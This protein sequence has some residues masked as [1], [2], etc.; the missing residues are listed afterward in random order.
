MRIGILGGG[1]LARMLALSG[2]PLGLDFVFFESRDEHCVAHLGEVV[3]GTFDDRDAMDAFANQ[4]DVITLENENIPAQAVHYLQQ[5]KPIRPGIN[6]LSY[7]QDRFFEKSLMREL[8]IPIPDCHAVDDKHALQ[9]AALALGFPF[10]LKT[11]RGGYDGKGQWRFTSQAELEDFNLPE[12]DHGYLAETMVTFDREVSLIGVRA[13]NGECRYYPLCENKHID[14]ILATT[15]VQGN[16][17]L[18]AQAEKILTQL[19][20]QLNYVGVLV[21]EFFV[22]GQQLWVNE[23]APRVHNS[24]HWS[25]EGAVCSQFENHCRAIADLP[26]GETRLLAPVTMHNI[27]GTW[28]DVTTLLAQAGLHLHDYQKSPRPG[29]KLGHYTSLALD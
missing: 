24:G 29:R 21:V 14:G 7:S 22:Q 16:D 8:Q 3:K 2:K 5:Q 1:Q 10:I 23:M 27:I 9:Q 4:V 26:L 20:T 28:P 12:N 19:L 13:Q 6:A 18:Q 11:R 15:Q 25:I 17:P